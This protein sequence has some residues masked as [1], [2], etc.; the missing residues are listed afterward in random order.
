[1]RPVVLSERL[2]T[3]AGMV[4]GGNR[5]CDVGCDHGFVPIYLVQQGI[6]PGVL[7][8]DL[9]EG[10]LRAAREHVSA[11][12]LDEKIETRLSDGLHN[13]KAGEADS[14]IC[15]GMGGG[16]M[17]RIL[18]AEREKTDSFQELVLQPQSEIERF[19]R[20]LRES[21][22]RILNEEMLAEDGK[23]YQVI[24]AAGPGGEHVQID[25]VKGR[26]AGPEGTLCADIPYKELC[27]LEDRYG[28]VLLRKRTPV[29]L[30]FLEREATVYEEILANL[31]KQGLT[32]EKR[33]ARY[34]EVEILLRDNR[35]AITLTR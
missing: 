17:I 12:G 23:Y 28:P 14:L 16:L 25:A 18:E 8:M 27:K 33:N 13:Y 26:D 21:G 9:R 1:M 32:E 15:A 22:Y 20:F 4:T 3:V 11:Y 24:R 29:F 5:V 31:R 6:S 35:Q 7:A 19:R 30:S 34:T 2:R 10:P